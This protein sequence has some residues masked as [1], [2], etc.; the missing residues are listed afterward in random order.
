MCRLQRCQEHPPALHKAFTSI[1]NRSLKNPHQPGLIKHSP[2]RST[3]VLT[4]LALV[5]TDWPIWVSH[6]AGI[7]GL[8][9]LLA[10]RA[11]CVCRRS[12]H[13]PALWLQW[14]QDEQFCITLP[15]TLLLWSSNG[16][17]KGKGEQ[18]WWEPGAFQPLGHVDCCHGVDFRTSWSEQCSCGAAE[19]LANESSRY[20]ARKLPKISPC[21]SLIFTVLC[22]LE[23]LSVCLGVSS[24]CA[25]HV[26]AVESVGMLLQDASLQSAGGWRSWCP[27]E[28]HYSLAGNPTFIIFHWEVKANE[29]QVS[30]QPH[31]YQEP[32]CFPCTRAL[33]L[34]LL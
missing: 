6:P 29:S 2:Q 7:W 10:C 14:P 16:V 30:Q 26:W 12:T 34:F 5:S 22:F 9:P 31:E 21:N 17:C 3:S 24:A 33:S 18:T 13:S 28:T 11:V 8:D 23:T 20:S 15:S 4:F 1:P 32:C 27:R 25:S 19:V